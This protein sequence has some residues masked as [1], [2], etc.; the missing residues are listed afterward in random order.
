MVA[1]L[2]VHRV[3]Q[4]FPA[5]ARSPAKDVHRRFG[6]LYFHGSDRLD[7]G[8]SVI[9]LW[10]CNSLGG[11]FDGKSDLSAA[12]A[13]FHQCVDSPIAGLHLQVAIRS[14]CP[15]LLHYWVYLRARSFPA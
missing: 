8:R 6:L 7:S 2:P 12:A 15:R 11:P 14:V 1:F 4:D 10:I 13:E 5:R 3:A 9:L